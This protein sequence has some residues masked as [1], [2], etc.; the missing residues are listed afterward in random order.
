MTTQPQEHEFLKLLVDPARTVWYSDG[1]R[2]PVNSGLSVADFVRHVQYNQHIG[3]FVR[4]IGSNQNAELI[5]GLSPLAVQRGGW[6]EVAAPAVYTLGTSN[7]PAEQLYTMRRCQL[8]A[9]LGG[10]H[11][12]GPADYPVYA[13]LLQLQQDLDFTPAVDSWLRQIPVFSRLEFVPDLNYPW[14]AYLLSFIVDPRWFIDPRHP[15][16]L[17]KL[18]AFL[19]LQLRNVQRV[20]AGERAPGTL[21]RCET[22]MMA[23]RSAQPPKEHLQHPQHFLWRAWHAAGTGITG[24]LRATQLFVCYLRHTW[25]QSL[26]NH[27]ELFVPE[28]FFKHPAEIAAYKAHTRDRSNPV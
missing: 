10:W 3:R 13:M 14:L 6:L 17:A 16:R 8:P 23:W 26:V 12:L 24:D 25:L 27:P 7:T 9:G 20:R 15:H 18:K 4:V 1:N 21:T 11:R 5:C 2:N 28:L 22:A 19:G